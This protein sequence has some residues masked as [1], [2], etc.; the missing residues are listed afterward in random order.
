MSPAMDA[1]AE[2]DASSTGASGGAVGGSRMGPYAAAYGQASG[3]TTAPRG[4]SG[5]RAR[6]V[7][8]RVSGGDVVINVGAHRR[9]S[10]SSSHSCQP[11]CV[12]HALTLGPRARMSSDMSSTTRSRRPHSAS[13]PAGDR[14]NA[15][16]TSSP[17]APPLNELLARLRRE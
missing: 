14:S 17:R 1:S 15:A 16:L 7:G 4:H 2:R 8:A 10:S 11:A 5:A 12:T 13:T 6:S 9:R 3:M